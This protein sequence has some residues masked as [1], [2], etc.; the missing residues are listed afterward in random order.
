MR[1]P[2]FLTFACT[3][4]LLTLGSCNGPA[5]QPAST[6]DTGSQPATSSESVTE[7]RPATAQGPPAPLTGQTFRL[8]S[9]PLKGKASADDLRF[10]I[11]LYPSQR[12]DSVLIAQDAEPSELD[13]DR[14]AKQGVPAGAVSV[15]QTYQAGAGY[16]YYAVAENNRLRV[17]RKLLEET[18]PENEGTPLPQWQLFKTFS[19]FTD[20]VQEEQNMP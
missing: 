17:Y 3:T 18:T 5:E 2:V 9:F 15:F 8:K 14:W 10:G 20:G 13:R 6:P 12:P 11:Y 19:F 16:Y 1:F 4:G 7:P